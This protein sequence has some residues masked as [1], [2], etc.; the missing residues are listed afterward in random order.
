MEH[1]NYE[2][3]SKDK[4]QL[5]KEETFEGENNS[6]EVQSTASKKH[7]QKKKK[8]VISS[9]LRYGVFIATLWVVFCISF[10]LGFVLHFDLKSDV[11]F[12]SILWTFSFI[13]CVL[14][15]TY[16]ILL[17]KSRNATDYDTKV[18]YLKFFPV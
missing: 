6:V 17:Y 18:F 1:Q 15:T 8:V 16:S 11:T 9:P 12:S 2:Q 3:L 14:A 7:T 4:K 13:I 5:T 10:I